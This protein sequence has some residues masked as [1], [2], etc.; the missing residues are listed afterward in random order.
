MEVYY[1]LEQ[2]NEIKRIVFL[3]FEKESSIRLKKKIVAVFGSM[4]CG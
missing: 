3:S 1:K 4:E 2:D